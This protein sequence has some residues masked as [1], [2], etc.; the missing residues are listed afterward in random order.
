M[1]RRRGRDRALAPLRRQG[2][3][4]SFV[5]ANETHKV[6]TKQ[7]A[8]V[9]ELHK[10]ESADS[11][12]DGTDPLLRNAPSIRNLGLRQACIAPGGQQQ[13][14]EDV[15]FRSMECLGHWGRI[16]GPP[17]AIVRLRICNF[18]LDEFTPIQEIPMKH[19]PLII[20]L[21]LAMCLPTAFAQDA[22]P[23]ERKLLEQMKQA[24]RAQGMTITPEMEA[25]MLQRYRETSAGFLGLRMAVE[26]QREAETAPAAIAP[27][28]PKAATPA[29][30]PASTPPVEGPASSAGDLGGVLQPHHQA[31]GPATFEEAADG[32]K[33]NGRLWM[34]PAGK[35]QSFGGD[36]A[37][38][39]VTYM[40]DIGGG[41]QDVKY[42]N[43]N[44]AAK[45]VTIGTMLITE[46]R[47]A[48]TTL[49][50]QEIGGDGFVAMAD[51][52]LITRPG[53]MFLYR[54]GQA[55][56][57]Q[58]M[59]EGYRVLS[60]Q[61][62]AAST[63]YVLAVW[64]GQ[65]R[66]SG[67]TSQVPD[68]ALLEVSSGRKVVVPRTRD[69][70][71]LRPAVVPD[72]RPIYFDAIQWFPTTIGPIAIV[73]NDGD[74]RVLAIHLPTN[75]LE[76]LFNRL[77]GINSWRAEPTSEGGIRVQAQLGL[78]GGEVADVREKFGGAP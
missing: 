3:S 56:H 43:V 44:S 66:F 59:P 33:A 25:Q 47:A 7:C 14:P 60:R 22:T 50:G 63:G 31:R 13:L 32:F 54:P 2:L 29:P 58:T 45:P 12:L 23:Q 20:S 48:L 38:G 6:D 18:H 76:V 69:A 4:G 5:I 49:D 15:G 68:F 52:V 61:V 74:D 72:R 35:I 75:R 19:V 39:D 46:D 78:R 77:M 16:R 17:N 64:T 26:A 57:S 10:I 27:V 42:A 71:R 8:E 28:P 21:S 36:P 70:T 1:R 37:T 40:V 11:A 67:L 9:L 55:L 62:N 51:G 41:R 65:S 24:A 34:D 53:A 73:G 30:A